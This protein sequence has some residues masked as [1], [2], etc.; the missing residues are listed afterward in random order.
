VDVYQ[1]A[2]TIT[3]YGVPSYSLMTAMIAASG[4]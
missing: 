2:N 3:S 4:G 1:V